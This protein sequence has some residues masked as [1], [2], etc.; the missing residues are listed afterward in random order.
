M[1]RGKNTAALGAAIC[2]PP[3][4]A[5]QRKRSSRENSSDQPIVRR[6]GSR[7][8]I[9]RS[10]SHSGAAAS[11]VVMIEVS[12]LTRTISVGSKNRKSIDCMGVAAK[13]F[14]VSIDELTNL[15]R[16]GLVTDEGKVIRLR[17]L[18]FSATTEDVKNF[19]K[20]N[21]CCGYRD[22]VMSSQTVPQH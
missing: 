9:S 7:L 15:K 20:G 21:R 2:S 6:P 11:I 19:F 18:P 14:T 4:A 8:A 16:A 3:L 13:V 1:N 5:R 10:Y 12:Q 22:M 17:G